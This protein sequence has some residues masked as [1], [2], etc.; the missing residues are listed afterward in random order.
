MHQNDVVNE[1]LREQLLA[2]VG[3]KSLRAM[4]MK[5]GIEPS[6]LHRQLDSGVKVETIVQICRA[7]NAP[8]LPAFVLAGFITEDEATSIQ[9]EA[10]LAKATERQLV[11]ETLRRVMNGSA[12]SELTEPVSAEAIDTVAQEQRAMSDATSNVTH[13]R[14]HPRDMSIEEL[15]QLPGAASTD[16]E[17]GTDEDFE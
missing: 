5:A 9:V 1:T 6:K 13:M 8:M 16:P 15:E 2:L 17:A 12:T 14:R 10:A 7:Y 11:E 3:E 4:A